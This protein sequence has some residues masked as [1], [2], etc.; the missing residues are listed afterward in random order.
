[1]FTL[2]VALLAALLGGG[3]VVFAAGAVVY[4]A[5]EVVDYQPGSGVSPALTTPAAV[6]SLPSAS[7]GASAADGNFS[8]FN[9]HYRPGEI[10]QVGHGGH[11]TLRLERFVRV[12]PGVFHLGVWE[13]VFLAATS[14]GL[15][16]QPPGLFGVDT[17]DVEVSADGMNF[18]SLGPV[19]FPGFG[20]FWADSSGPYSKT[21]GII[22]ADFGRPF[23]RDLSQLAG[24]NFEQVLAFL[25]GTAGG[26]WID[27]SPSGLSHVGWVRFSGVTEGQTLEI[28]AIAIN[29]ALAGAPTALP[30]LTIVHNNVG[31]VM[32]PHSLP[33]A[34]YQ[35]QFSDDLAA[36]W[37]DL[38]EPLPGSGAELVFNDPTTPRPAS[39]FYRIILP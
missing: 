18:V 15:V 19:A 17:A 2:R 9:P 1:M 28:D 5:A 34:S 8:P 37:H 24:A 25:E 32:L 23:N 3:G 6:L 22:R 29:T 31:R 10:V 27:L 4:T 16:S 30:R 20:N 11:L 35:L 13:N 38:G 21:S 7:T 14:E 36:G 26:T 12:E 33:H 39:R